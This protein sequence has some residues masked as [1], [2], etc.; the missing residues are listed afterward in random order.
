MGALVICSAVAVAI[1]F[2]SHA[3]G[4]S[5][6]FPLKVYIPNVTSLSQKFNA[7]TI[8]YDARSSTLKASGK[9]EIESEGII[10]VADLVEYNQ[11]KN[12]V[13]ASGNVAIL[14]EDGVVKFVKKAELTDRIKSRVID[15]FRTEMADSAE[16]MVAERKQPKITDVKIAGS[17]T[18]DKKPSL[19]EKTLAYLTPASSD[20]AARL[21]HLEPAA[22]DM[23]VAGD[24]PVIS[25]VPLINLPEAKPE[26]EIKPEVKQ[27]IPVAKDSSVKTEK[28]EVAVEVK[29]DG[30][31][32]VAATPEN[33]QSPVPEE[34]P[35]KP[36]EQ[37]VVKNKP[38]EKSAKNKA[39]SKSKS[40]SKNK[41][42][43]IAKAEPKPKTGEPEESLSPESV[44]LL[45]K[46]APLATAE[47]KTSVPSSLDINH[48]RGMQ[49]LFKAD[50]AAPAPAQGEL[51]GV[52]VEKKEQKL[53]LDSELERAYNAISAGQN[54][55]AIDTYKNVLSNAPNNTNALF[56]LATLYHR[57]R[58]FDKARPL[59]GRLLAIDPTNRD[60]FNNFLV[61]LA[62]EAPREAIIEL[63]KLEAKNPGFSTIPA[64]LAVIYQKLGENDKAIGKMFRAVALAP[65]NLTYRYNL[66][67][68]LDKQ[69]N[70]DEAAKLYKQLIEAVQ[71][72]EKI[73]GNVD[74]I[75]QRLTFISSNRP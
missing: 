33:T 51:L 73:P 37:E 60:G 41:A 1:P 5:R 27:E 24:K 25:D 28:P 42:E 22:G 58:Q 8:E 72:G 71:R 35:S 49:D 16:L 13:I 62:D 12:T 2:N 18:G 15:T 50:A 48:T 52:K 57:A 55:I 30:Q 19:W 47:K 11:L 70:Y 63:E 20:T 4:D 23:A 56:G 3:D 75:Q 46:V 14:G 68:M 17:S 34:K 43:D 74:N 39:T 54:E 9:V 61:L 45:D 53:N 21:S 44:K 36:Q 38:E 64:Q 6:L 7:D 26:V 66:A 40:A 10:V 59:Y 67:I 69:K 29:K 31:S 65:E 32:Q